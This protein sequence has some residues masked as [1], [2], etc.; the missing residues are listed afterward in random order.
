[1][2][3]VGHVMVTFNLGKQSFTHK[4]LV[5]RFLTR[6]FILGEDYLSKNCMRMEWDGNKRAISYMSNILAIAS[7]EVMEEPLKL[8]NA[9]KIPARSF[10]VAPTYCSQMFTG[11]VCTRPSNEMKH[12]FPNLYMEPIQFNN[13]EGKQQKQIPYMIINLDYNDDVYI[14]KNTHTA[15]IEEELVECNYIEV[16]ESIETTE[17]CNWMPKR[18]IVNSNLVYSPAQ[19]TE[20]RRVE[21]RDQDVPKETKQEFDKLKEDYPEVF[22]LN[23]Q[24]IGHTQLVTM[25]VDTG[26]SPPIYQ[27]PYTLPLKH[28]SWVQ[29]EIE[30]LEQAGIIKKSLS[31]WASPIVVVP[32]KSGPG[33]PPRWRMC[34]DFRKINDLQPQ[35]RRVDSATSGNISLVPLPKIDEMYAALHGAKIFTTLDLRSGYYHINLDEESKAKTAFMTPFG[36][37]EFNS[38]PFGLAQAPAYFQQLISMVLQDCRDFVMAYLDD[39]IIF[40]R[41]PEEH[42]KHIEIIFQK[43][44]AAGLK[45]KESKCDFFKSEIYYFG[46]LISDKGIQPLLEK[47][48]TIRNMPHPRTPKEI[49]QFLGLTGYY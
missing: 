41:T 16:C 33:E 19:V 11:R 27:K 32:K 8:C 17:C 14:G 46:H 39:I 10:V 25:H 35:V 42:L 15:Y 23:N 18:E 36:K 47:L 28:Y 7:Q 6:P 1:M 30:T 45:L 43:L 24:D 5:C 29:Q 48:D 31:P 20:H 40:S 44:K 2:S 34:V 4:F 3:V 22:S 38:V 37:Y 12:K 26:D 49:K 13:S 9:I 21:L